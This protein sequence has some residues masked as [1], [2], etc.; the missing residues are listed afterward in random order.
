MQAGL[1]GRAE[2]KQMPARRL[3][4]GSTD[5]FATANAQ[6]NGEPSPASPA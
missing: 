1:K 2:S 6:L 4:A 3:L 5:A